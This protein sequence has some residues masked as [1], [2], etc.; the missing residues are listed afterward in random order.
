[1]FTWNNDLLTGNSVIDSQHKDIYKKLDDVLGLTI[2]RDG[3]AEIAKVFRYL[4]TYVFN[5]FNSEEE[6][7]KQHQYP[8]YES[9]RE[10]HQ[11]FIKKIS[12]LN[13]QLKEQGVTVDFTNELK[14][15]FIELLAEHIDEVD[16]R[17]VAFLNKQ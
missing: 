2:E 8:E 15:V 7:M 10:D 11:N 3:E 5:H 12:R 9:H 6:L 16:R 14:L 4:V 13:K 1:M 17:F